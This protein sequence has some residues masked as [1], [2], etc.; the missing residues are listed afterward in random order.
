MI[1]T[2]EN[3]A[4]R[5]Q[6][7]SLGAELW[8]LW[9]KRSRTE[10]LWQGDPLVWPRRAPTL[11]PVCGRLKNDQY[12]VSGR[13]FKLPMHGFARDFEHIALEQDKTSVTFLLGSNN[14][15]IKLYP[16]CFRLYTRFELAEHRL[17]HSFRVENLNDAEMLFSLGYHTGYKCPFDDSH[18]IEDYSLIFDEKET[19]VEILCHDG[20]LS[21]EKSVYFENRR[22]IPLGDELFPASFILS[23]L[24]SDFVSLV[25]KDTGRAIKVS[26]QNFPHVVFWS[27]PGKVKF[28]CIEPWYGLPDPNNT[29][30][31]LDQ[32]PGIQKLR[33]NQH[34]ACKM[35]IDL[36]KQEDTINFN[37]VEQCL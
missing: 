24:K 22:C 26:I 4:L 8:S 12:T 16:Y 9:D 30:G 29:V 13:T 7:N 35:T 21:G 28:V 1:Y 19:P 2:I 3:D 5:V 15:S 34:F 31:R 33:P 11:F 20:F 37:E 32:K 10:L 23:N 17:I 25:E 18:S 36:G 6:I 27:A 14:E